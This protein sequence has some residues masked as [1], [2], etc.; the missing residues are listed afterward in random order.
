MHDDEGKVFLT[1][2]NVNPQFDS[3]SGFRPK[4]RFKTFQQREIC[5]TTIGATIERA[6]L[7]GKIDSAIFFQNESEQV[8]AFV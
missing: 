8:V 1:H 3:V 5:L 4:A 7:A 2:P 6:E